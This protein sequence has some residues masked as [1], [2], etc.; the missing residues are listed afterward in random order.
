MS[1]GGAHV[2]GGTI[3]ATARAEISQNGRQQKCSANIRL[4]TY[5]S[6]RRQLKIYDTP[7]AGG[8]PPTPKPGAYAW[9][10][11]IAKRSA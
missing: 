7:Q 8:D 4:I 3:N 5:L 2:T 6:N 10:T 11:Y 1:I 9:T